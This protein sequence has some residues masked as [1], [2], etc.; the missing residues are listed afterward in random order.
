[1]PL[2]ELASEDPGMPAGLTD[3]DWAAR[4]GR[5]AAGEPAHHLSLRSAGPLGDARRYP[6]GG[7]L[8]YVTQTC[9]QDTAN[10]GP[11]WS[12]ASPRQGP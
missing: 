4:Y 11:T 1:V 5:P 2:E 8:I 10:R 7:Y 12:P 3:R 6:L 9:D